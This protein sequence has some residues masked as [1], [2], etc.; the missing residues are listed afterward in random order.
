MAPTMA[1]TLHPTIASI[2][3]RAARRPRR[4]AACAT[5]RA[6]PAPSAR[7]IPAEERGTAREAGRCGRWSVPESPD[8]LLALA[9]AREPDEESPVRSARPADHL[10]RRSSRP[11]DQ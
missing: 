6:P 9:R 1:P 11:Q 7:T 5:P 8:T 3:T 2:G 10:E 4:T